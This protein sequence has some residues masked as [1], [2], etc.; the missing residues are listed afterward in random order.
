MESRL[1]RALVA[2][3][4][5]HKDIAES[6]DDDRQQIEDIATGRNAHKLYLDNE[7]DHIRDIESER[8]INDGLISDLDKDKSNKS[9]S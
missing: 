1:D 9:Q 2:G 6:I 5:G 7:I 3:V 4:F 8:S